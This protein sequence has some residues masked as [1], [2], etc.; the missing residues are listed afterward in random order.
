MAQQCGTYTGQLGAAIRDA[1][2]RGDLLRVRRSRQR[3]ALPRRGAT[4]RQ[5]RRA[6][7]A[8]ARCAP[9]T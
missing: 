6:T 7:R 1:M 5:P 8:D 3:P 2:Q 9:R 4:A